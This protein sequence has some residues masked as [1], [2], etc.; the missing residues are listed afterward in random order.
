LHLTDLELSELASVLLNSLAW[1]VAL[2]FC[3][4]SPPGSLV[5]KTRALLDM[6]FSCHLKNNFACC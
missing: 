1:K 4:A 6:T 2:N 5:P 3:S